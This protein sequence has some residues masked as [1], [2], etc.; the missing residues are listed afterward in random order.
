VVG[1]GVS[2]AGQ[3]FQA[4]IGGMERLKALSSLKAR[5]MM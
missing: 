4:D 2:L 1:V 5:G 3:H